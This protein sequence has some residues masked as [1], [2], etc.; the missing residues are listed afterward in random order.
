MTKTIT[1][2]STNTCAYCLQVKKWLTAKGLSY[3]EINLD[4]QPEHIDELMQ[5]S[6][7]MAVPVTVVT[8]EDTKQQSVTVGWDLPKL[9]DAVKDM[10]NQS[11]AT[12]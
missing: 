5:V 7:Q 4:Q 10:L 11:P 9:T 6:G 3:Q 2:Y 8:D 1:V 12:A